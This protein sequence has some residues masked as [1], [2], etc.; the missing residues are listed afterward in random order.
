M[1]NRSVKK[2]R[3][4]CPPIRKWRPLAPEDMSATDLEERADQRGYLPREERGLAGADD[5][6]QWLAILMNEKNVSCEELSKQSGVPTDTIKKW[7]KRD[8]DK[9]KIP[10]LRSMQACLEALGQ[11]L[12]AGRAEI[13][14]KNDIYFYPVMSFRQELR[15]KTIT[16]M[17]SSRG[18]SESELVERQEA[19]HEEAVK[20]GLKAPRRR[21]T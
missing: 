19:E 17:A 16:Q 14:I 2:K 6:V 9:R 1:S 11:S 4:I 21:D 7:F 18:I 15:E 5:I 13:I 8:Q 20:R 10:T 12:I 3:K